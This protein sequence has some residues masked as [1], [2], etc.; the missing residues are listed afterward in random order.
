MEKTSWKYKFVRLVEL[1][2]AIV[3]HKR[4][5]SKL[6]GVPIKEIDSAYNE[7]AESKFLHDLNK[8][9]VHPK[10]LHYVSMFSPF[11]A[12]ILYLIC[13]FVKPDVVI[14]TGVKDGFSTSFTLYALEMNKKGR[15]YSI[16]LPNRPG[17]ELRETQS[18]GW[19]V[20]KEF[21][22]RW[23]LILGSSRDKLPTLLE[24]VRNVD[25]FFHDSDHSYENM[26]FE[27]DK[28]WGYLMP[29]GFLLVDDIT[30]NSA[31]S[32]FIR[33]RGC[34]SSLELFKTGIVIKY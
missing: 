18:T 31:F 21:H 26:M 3:T 23:K 20:P 17:Q 5:L 11:R 10:I 4:K 30:E 22:H 6:L 14:E 29:K 15:L 8:K 27:F 1:A 12:P 34:K 28:A 16:D 19:L 33:K 25:I 7:L 24:N 13:R 9:T 2:N 32:E